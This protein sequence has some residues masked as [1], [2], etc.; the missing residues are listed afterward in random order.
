MQMAMED[1]PDNQS[2][3]LETK[4][5]KHLIRGA[6]ELLHEYQIQSFLQ[7]IDFPGVNRP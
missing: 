4:V 3:T 2:Q 1:A 6:Q 5:W 7:L